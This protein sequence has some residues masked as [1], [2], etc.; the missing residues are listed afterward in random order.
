VAEGASFETAVLT[1]YRMDLAYLERDW[2][3]GLGERFRLLPMVMTGTAL[4][5]GIALL[6]IVAF[7]RRR[8]QQRDKLA[9]WEQ[10]EADAERALSAL[11]HA[12]ATNTTISV[13]DA[14][15]PRVLHVYALPGSLREAG[16]PTIEHEGQRHTLH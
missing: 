12:E 13:A 11:A 1:A 3:Q 10:E 2:R 16:V 14:S 15:E 8:R 7:A 9:R 4:W 5:G 6:A